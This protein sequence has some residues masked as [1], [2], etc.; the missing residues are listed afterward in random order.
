MRVSDFTYTVQLRTTV[1]QTMFVCFAKCLLSKVFCNDL[2]IWLQ[3]VETFFFIFC[4]DEEDLDE[5]VCTKMS[6]INSAAQEFLNT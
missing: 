4:S 6:K 5:E 2:D 3:L 1:M